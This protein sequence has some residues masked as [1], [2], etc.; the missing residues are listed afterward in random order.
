MLRL[1]KVRVA[2]LNG[3]STSAAQLGAPEEPEAKDRRGD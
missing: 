3:A 2:A 1:Q